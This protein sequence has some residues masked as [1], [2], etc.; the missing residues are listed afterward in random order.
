[1]AQFKSFE[2]GVEVCGAAVLSIV[3]GMD[4]SRTM[5]RRVLSAHGIV[6]P[7]RESWHPQQA[8]LDAFREIAGSVGPA[9]L[10]RIGTKIPETALWPPSIRTI[11][12]AL[13]SIDIAYH[14]NH[15]GGEVGH[16]AFTK[17]ASTTG[18]MVCGNPYPCEFDH[19]IVEATA[20][21][22]APPRLVVAVRHDDA[23]PCRS[24]GGDSC[25]YHVSW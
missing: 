16:Y 8:W 13:S 20:A 22:F 3:E 12:D 11:E 2:A 23:L 24:R 25:T 21:K 1:M 5:A 18:S 10:R 7:T 9:T 4:L 6:D 15:R 19:G 14:M 17:S